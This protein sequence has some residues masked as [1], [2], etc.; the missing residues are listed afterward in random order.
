MLRMAGIMTVR[1]YRDGTWCASP[2]PKPATPTR[3]FVQKLSRKP[4]SIIQATV[5]LYNNAVMAVSRQAPSVAVLRCI[6]SVSLA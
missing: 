4:S 2:V 1:P 5:Q 3:D 6:N